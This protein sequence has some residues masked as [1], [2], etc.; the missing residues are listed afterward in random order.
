MKVIGLMSGTSADGVDAALVDIRGTGHDLRV[1]LLAFRTV[2]YPPAF[3]ARLLHE[4]TDG[5]LS[6]VCHLNAALGDWFARAALKILQVAKLSPHRVSLIGSHGQTF[7]H[8]PVPRREPVLGPIRSTLQLGSPAVVA[9]RTGITTV[10]DF[11]MRDMAAGGEGAPLA[12]YLHHLLFRHASLTRAVVN[13]GGISNLTYLPCNGPLRGV[14][15]FDTGPGNML[16]DGL[17]RRLTH[18]RRGFDADGRLARQGK[19]H[20]RLLRQWLRHPYLR[21]RPPKST[22]REEFG[23]A[24]LK[25]IIRNGQRPGLSETDVIATATAYT[26]RTIADARKFLPRRPDEVL[27]CGGGAKNMTLMRMLQEA[28]REVPIRTV[29]AFGWDGR[30]LEA[31]AFAVFAYQTMHGL[32]CNLPSVTGAKR[33]VVLGSVT[34]GNGRA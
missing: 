18:G 24:F 4:M 25:E 21:R 1:K 3:R 5:R 14:L 31:V 20:E 10:A 33:T 28:W 6:E 30:A 27:I 26:A 2:S 12:P 8:L 9:E 16:I 32:P 34:P 23:E 15:A 17:V 13:I 7:H 22:G 11:R 29:E 19:V